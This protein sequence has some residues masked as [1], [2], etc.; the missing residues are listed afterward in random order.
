MKIDLTGR[1]AV[2]TGGSRGIGQGIA[3]TLH[4][5]GAKVAIFGRDAANAV[6]AAEALGAG[7][8]GY[9]CD[10]AVATEGSRPRPVHQ[11]HPYQAIPA[12][13]PDAM[14]Q[15]APASLVRRQKSR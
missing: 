6:A 14:P 13:Y 2:V 3:A 10:V 7:A 12:R 1:V 9:R 5:A 15:N 8:K 11:A 4:A